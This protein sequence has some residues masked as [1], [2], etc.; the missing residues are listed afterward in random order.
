[1]SDGWTVQ[2]VPRDGTGTRSFRISPRVVGAAAGAV[3]LLAVLVAMWFVFFAGDVF[4]AAE[5]ADLREENRELTRNLS[6]AE[7]RTQVLAGS[8]DA[9]AQR[10]ERFR[11]MAG[12]P[13]I[14]PDI[15][16]VGVGGPATEAADG[17]SA[18]VNRNLDRLLR[19]SRLLSSSVSEAIDS[20]RVH[21]EV[22]LSRPSIRPVASEDSWI[23]SSYSHSRYHPILLHNRPHTGI[24]ISARHGAPFLASARGTVEFA[25]EESGYGKMVEIDHGYG[26]TTRYAH[27]A[28]LE[29]REGETVRRGAVLGRVGETGLTT[30]PNLHYEVLV[31]GRPVDPRP[32]LLDDRL[33]Q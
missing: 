19:R 12:L 32:F 30:G 5:L 10:E 26:Y 27:A 16:E 14:D 29:V 20:L 1:M 2:I 8:M 4:R 24:D 13:L 18:D 3:G 15:R 9:L 17:R 33:F 7:R 11:L 22:F 6:A 28:S 23:S 31:D 21:R 25:G